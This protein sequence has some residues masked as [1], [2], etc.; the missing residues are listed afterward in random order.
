MRLFACYRGCVLCGR[1]SAVCVRMHTRPPGGAHVLCFEMLMR[2]CMLAYARACVCLFACTS[3]CVG[4][5]AYASVCLC[6]W[7]RMQVDTRMRSGVL[8]CMRSCAFIGATTTRAASRPC[9]AGSMR[10]SV[11]MRE[12]VYA[13]WRMRACMLM[14][15]CALANVRVLLYARMHIVGIPGCM[16]VCMY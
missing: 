14:R 16:Q 8:G 5:F 7:A 6:V 10:G 4:L 2:A 15:A 9:A 11:P 13:R 1:V 3:E 12:Y